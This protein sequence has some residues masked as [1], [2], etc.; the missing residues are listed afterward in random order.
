MTFGE[1]KIKNG[2]NIHIFG[3]DKGGWLF[4]LIKIHKLFYFLIKFWYHYYNSL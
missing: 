3:Y 2:D 1:N 4:I